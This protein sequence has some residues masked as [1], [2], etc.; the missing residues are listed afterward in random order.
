[1][2]ILPVPKIELIEVNELTET[3]RGEQGFSSTEA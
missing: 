2:V 3:G 1:M